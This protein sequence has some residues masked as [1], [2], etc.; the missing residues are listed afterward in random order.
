MSQ[1]SYRDKVYA[2]FGIVA[3]GI[4]SDTAGRF[5]FVFAG[6]HIDC[7]LSHFGCKVVEHDAVYATQVKHLLQFVEVAYFDF[8][9]QV[10][11]LFLAVIL[12]TVDRLRTLIVKT[13]IL[14]SFFI[15]VCS[16]RC[17]LASNRQTTQTYVRF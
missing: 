16:I 1:S 8:N 9:L 12:G 11:A 4:E 15:F 3:K 17:I 5:C 14:T 7:L 2:T 13:I 10:L 6:Y